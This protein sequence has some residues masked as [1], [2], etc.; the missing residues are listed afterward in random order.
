MSPANPS[1]DRSNRQ[2]SLSQ[3]GRAGVAA[4]GAIQKCAAAGLRD[5]AA[6]QFYADPAGSAL[7]DARPDGA[8]PVAM[9]RWIAAGRDVAARN[10]LYRLERF[11]QAYVALGIYDFG[12]P[13]IEERRALFAST[14]VMAVDEAGVEADPS[15]A[16]P[17]YFEADWHLRPGGWDGYDLYGP[18]GQHVIG[19]IFK[20]GGFAAAPVGSNIAR[21]RLDVI[22]QLPR[23]DYA[24]IYEPGCG[25]GS[26]LMAIHQ[27]FPDAELVASDLSL[28]QLGAAAAR[29]RAASVSAQLKQRDAA[30][31][32]GEPASSVDAVVTFALHHE[33]PH[34]ANVALLAE[35]FRI[36]KPGGDIVLSDPPPFRAVDPFL[37]VLLDWDTDNRGEPFFTESGM[38]DWAQVMRDVGFVDARDYAVGPASYPWVTIARKPD[39]VAQR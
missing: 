8:D 10:S 34:D 4:L 17:D 23:T 11:F 27:T 21:H 9:A 38:S 31:D 29:L 36:L 22:G 24:R 1:A 7:R 39:V 16:M 30:T 6:E 25:N 12:I 32:T 28:E 15:L 35:M 3:H 18:H 33:L 14:G 37:A 2:P 19:P 13:A 26:T 5:A 20:L